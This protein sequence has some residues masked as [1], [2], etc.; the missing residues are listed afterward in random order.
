VTIGMSEPLTSERR[1][2]LKGVEG[3]RAIAALSVVAYHVGLMCG[4]SR[5]GTLAPLVAELKAGVAVFFVISGFV[6]YLPYARAVATGGS[7]P[8]WRSFAER[9]A[10]RIMPAYWVLLSVTAVALPATAVLGPNLWRYYGLA[11][12]YDP[13]TV[14]GGLGVA[15][16]LAV[17]VSFYL[18][19][20]FLALGL[21]SLAVRAGRDSIWRGQLLPLVLLAAASL[22]IRILLAR[23]LTA[24]VAQ[25][26]LVTATALPGSL[27]W[28]AA[29]MMLAV[30]A[31]QVERGWQLPRAVQWV[32]DHPAFCWVGACA[33]FLLVASIQTRDLFLMVYSPLVHALFGMMGGLLVLPAALAQGS[34]RHSR[35]RAWLASRRMV[36]LGTVSYGVYLCHMLVLAA[37][38]GGTLNPSLTPEPVIHALALLIVVA[39]GAVGC[40]A[41]SWYL[42][43]RPVGQ[44]AARRAVAAAVRAIA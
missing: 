40:G 41:L 44:L 9:R 26:H 34:R 6:L 11:Q 22:L 29:G 17:E 27:D 35:L 24:S 23:S 32:V 36:W 16:S 13:N 1:P 10:L 4:L 43:E 33:L 3:L 7:L 5:N 2:R 30:G 21:R 20:P 37:F 8:D 38:T 15:W 25:A 14:F 28:F 39:A 42:V 18:L 19:L 12:I 31:A